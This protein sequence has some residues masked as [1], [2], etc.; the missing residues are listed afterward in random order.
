MKSAYGP[1]E[2]G[3]TIIELL[4]VMGIA[5]ILLSFISINLIKAQQTTNISTAIDTMVADMKSQQIK[6]MNGNSTDGTAVSSFGITLN[7]SS[8][9]LFQGES[10]P[11]DS[12]DYDHAIDGVTAS[13]SPAGYNK[14]L[15]FEKLTGEIKSYL[16]LTTITVKNTIGTEQKTITVNKYGVIT[17]IN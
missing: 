10:D 7:N 13:L 4:L 1:M 2:Q 9:T 5:A 6:A 14:M 16:P 15:V 3:F 8:Y 11:H 17:N 12:T